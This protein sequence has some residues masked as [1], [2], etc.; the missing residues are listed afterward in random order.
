MIKHN[1]DKDC[2]LTVAIPTY[3]GSRTICDMLDILLPQVD[4]RVE[5]LVSDNCST[6]NIPQIIKKYKESYRK[7]RYIR[8]DVNIGPDANFLNALFM[9]KGKYVL[10]LSDDDILIE[11]SLVK[12]LD[13]LEENQDLT[14]I[15]L[16]TVGFHNKYT[17]LKNCIQPGHRVEENICTKDKK[18][19]MKYAGFYWG[20]MSSFICSKA[21]FNKIE[22]PER[23]FGTYWLQSYIHILCSADKEAKLGVV[24]GPCIGA[25]AYINVANFDTSLVDGVYYRKMLDF[26]VEMAGY[27][28][29]QLDNLYIRR[30]CILGKRAV[31]KEKALGIRKTNVQRLFNC[32]KKYPKA[33][34]MLYPFIILPTPVCKA[35]VTI[36]RKLKKSKG[37]LRI[38]RPE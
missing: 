5:V 23:F 36:Y 24:K 7:I 2:L 37:S 27:D 13:F 10:L 14:L 33:W 12:I 29:K 30:L 38:N 11:N 1:N 22:N 21:S 6:D 35:A 26:A 17:G 18:V 20:F 8:N 4:D 34:I 25:G 32:T 28:K 19:F 3:N 15:Y 9:A 16:H 31:I